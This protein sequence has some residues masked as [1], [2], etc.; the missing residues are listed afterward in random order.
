[1]LDIV[2][3]YYCM[4]FQGKLLIQ[5]KENGEKPNFEPD[6]V[7]WAQIWTAKILFQKSGPNSP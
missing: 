2:S 6:L 4:Q 5:N 3:S 1:M 7:C